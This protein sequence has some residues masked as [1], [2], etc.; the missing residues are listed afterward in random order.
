MHDVPGEVRQLFLVHPRRVAQHIPLFG[1]EQDVLVHGV[2]HPVNGGLALFHHVDVPKTRRAVL[3]HKQRVKHKR[4]LAVVVKTA[5]G[6]FRVVLAGVEHHP[7][8]ELAVV[9]H[10]AALRVPLFVVPVHHHALAVGVQPAVVEVVGHLQRAGAVA[11]QLGPALSQLVRVFQAQGEK[12]GGRLDIV[13]ARLPVEHQQVHGPHRDLAHTAPLFR[14]PEHPLDAGALLELA[15]PG[16]AVHLLIVRLFQHHRQHAGKHP[17]GLFIVRGPGQHIGGRVVVHGVSMLVSNGVEQP[18]A[19]R[20]RLALHHGVL[21]IF[22]VPHPEPQLVVHQ[23]L[24]QRRLADL[25]LLQ[26]LLCPRHLLRPD[27]R[28]VGP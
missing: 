13:H 25:V 24:V 15:P 5:S 26:D 7:V 11:L 19:G 12:V 22:P 27:G 4:I 1:G 17:R 8:A 21:V 2:V 6:V 14:V 16:V 28:L 18:P 9:E 20:L 3:L 23:P 10:P